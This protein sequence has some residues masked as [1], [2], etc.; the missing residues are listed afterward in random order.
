M[1]AALKQELFLRADYL[2]NK[3]LDTIYIGGGT[4]SL[5]NS[6]EL[7]DL[8]D[9]ILQIY[10]IAP[11]AEITLEANPDDLTLQ[12]LNE[13][14]Q[15]PINRLSIGIQSFNDADLLFMNRAHNA[16]QADFCI[17][18]AQD[19]GFDNLSIDLIYGSPSTTHAIWQQNVAK[20]LAYRTAHLSCYCLTV[21]PK[22]ALDSFVKR[23]K[24]PPVDEEQAAQ[25]FEYLI[26]CT[27]QAGYLHYEISNFCLPNRFAQ[28]NSSYWKGSNYLG[29]GPSAHS[30]NQ[31]SRQWNVANNAQYIKAINNHSIPAEIEQLS[32]NQQFNEY[33]LTSLRTIW[34]CDLAYINHHFGNAF[35]NYLQ[36]AIKQF[37]GLV[38]QNQ[39]ILSLNTKGKLLADKITSELFLVDE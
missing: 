35:A 15:T 8:F 19:M 13:L 6:H 24:A 26:H 7:N 16:T 17:K 32:T 30:F 10:S 25:Q 28:H 36:T 5:L 29:I 3:Q 21:E 38:V 18:A 20:A 14:R 12:K 23:K 4:P 33:L 27:E 22:T 31:T 34:G 11:T 1:L 39:N 37:D 9:A 2:P